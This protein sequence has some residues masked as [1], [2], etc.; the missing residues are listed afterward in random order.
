MKFGGAA[1]R[2]AAGFRKCAEIVRSRPNVMPVVVVSAMAGV[3]NELSAITD[4][5]ESDPSCVS[6][7]IE[8]LR[9]KHT[10]V[11]EEC[12]ADE[13]IRESCLDDIQQVLSGLERSLREIADSAGATP[14]T[15]DSV[16]VTGERLSARILAAVLNQMGCP[17][18]ARDA[19]D[20]GI[21]TDGVFGAASPLLKET[22]DN[23]KNTLSPM[24]E[25]GEVAVITGYFG[26]D[27]ESRPTTFGRGGSDFSA[28]IV[29]H[30]LGADEVEVWKDVPGF[31]SAD[32]KAVAD[33]RY[34]DEMGYEEAAELS[35][36]G[37]RILHPR[38]VEPAMDKKIPL[39]VKGFDDPE[40]PGTLVLAGPDET[41]AV[42][43]IAS[44]G[45]LSI[46]TLYGPAMAYTPGLA[47]DLFGSLSSAGI[48][49]YTIGTSMASLSVVV[50]G[51]DA[52]QAMDIF[53]KLHESIVHDISVRSGVSLICAAGAG[54][55]KNADVIGR[56]FKAVAES[57]AN[58]LLTADGGSKVAVILAVPDA[59][60]PEAI[61][62]IHREFMGNSWGHHTS[63]LL[64]L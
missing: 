34:I 59:D 29:G 56:I 9:G 60:C 21:L 35:Y 61:E 2:D 40:A 24:M 32:P 48:N 46:V 31:M 38:T 17:A 33:A 14:E 26:C 11:L 10:D 36:F 52:D 7:F 25:R 18:R 39:R 20:I 49:V 6:P 47:G 23:L 53:G 27:C 5:V 12:V 58:I 63:F 50:E 15:T 44:R 28:A 45:G 3:T 51:S 42:R 8:K 30:A 54:M 57:G 37:A 1:V 64:L 22:A 16:V 13:N 19:N 55:R 4:K 41:G 62:A 43:S